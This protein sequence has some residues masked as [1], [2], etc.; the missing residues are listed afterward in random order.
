MCDDQSESQ[1]DEDDWLLFDP[2]ET[3]SEWLSEADEKAY[4]NL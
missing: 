3:F 1:V 4:A 2:F